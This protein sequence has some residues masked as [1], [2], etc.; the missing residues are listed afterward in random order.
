MRLKQKDTVGSV[1]GRW[2]IRVIL[3][4]WAFYILRLKVMRNFMPMFGRFPVFLAL[5]IMN[6]PGIPQSSHP[7]SPIHSLR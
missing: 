7:I 5:K 2:I 3:A 1:I 4:A 6:L